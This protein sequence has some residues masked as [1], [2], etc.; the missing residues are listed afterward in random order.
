[1]IE[2]TGRERCSQLGGLWRRLP[3][4][5]G[6]AIIGV[7][8]MSGL[9]F[10]AGWTTKSMMT[11]AGWQLAV[12]QAQAGMGGGYALAAWLV[13]EALAVAVFIGAG[14]K[15]LWLVFVA[16]PATDDP[17]P[18]E[19]PKVAL[20]ARLPMLL[21]AGLC[22][23][24]GLLPTPIYELLPFRNDPAFSQV[25][26]F[27]KHHYTFAYVGKFLLS[28]LGLALAFALVLPLLRRGL[29]ST[30]DLD[31][32]Y[33]RLIPWCWQHVVLAFL[34][35]LGRF[36]QEVMDGLPAF[37]VTVLA[38]GRFSGRPLAIWITASMV[39]GVVVLLLLVEYINLG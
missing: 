35:P 7:L 22:V 13:L 27:V 32:L 30:L 14:M 17:L 6:C 19:L 18:A 5:F 23:M 39:V 16:R 4:T 1:M 21:F 9:P 31:A 25:G 36:Q 24:I 2:V 12:E 15:F 37:A 33:R 29:G 3:V 20:S 11:A 38:G 8:A 26:A 34:R 28:A 10:T